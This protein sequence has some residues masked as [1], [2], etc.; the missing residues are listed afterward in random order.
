MTPLA[1]R[2]AK[3]LGLPKDK[4]TAF[5]RGNVLDLF[6]QDLHCFEISIIQNNVL[7]AIDHPAYWEDAQSLSHGFFLPS[8]I[9]WLESKHDGKREALI[10]ESKG[11]RNYK[12]YKAF[13]ND[14]QIFSVPLEEVRFSGILEEGNR[15][16]INNAS[17]EVV[18][19]EFHGK[20]NKTFSIDLEQVAKEPLK[21]KIKKLRMFKDL[22][23]SQVAV[24]NDKL[25]A[26]ERMEEMTRENSQKER[27]AFILFAIGLINTPG[28]IGIKQHAPHKAVARMMA[29]RFPLRGWSEITL[30]HET[31]HYTG[32]IIQSGPAFHKCLHFVRSHKRHYKDGRVSIIPAHWRGD[33]ALGIKRTRYK[34]V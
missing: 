27:I 17:M 1:L 5:D 21:E 12:L 34:V 2:F 22:G 6:G 3:Q 16:K 18:F 24:L 31:V 13:E 10:I 7:H 19:S 28:I 33:P 23:E 20:T 25:Y 32:P 9:T 29:G 14:E 30:K 15:I 4:R 8:P 11:D 26:A